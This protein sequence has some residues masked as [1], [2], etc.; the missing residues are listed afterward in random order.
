[1]KNFRNLKLEK[2]YQFTWLE[3]YAELREVREAI[4]R[5]T[6]WQRCVFHLQQNAQSKV[7]NASQRKEIANI[8][9]DILSQFDLKNAKSLLKKYQTKWGIKVKKAFQMDRWSLFKVLYIFKV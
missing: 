3:A 7:T 9:R 4:F 1:L 6:P 5:A 2:P 8:L